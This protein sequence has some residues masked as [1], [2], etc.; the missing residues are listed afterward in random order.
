MRTQ[1]P[2]CRAIVMQSKNHEGPNF[3]PN[4]AN[5]FYLPQDER[6]MPP[7]ILGVLVILVANLQIISQ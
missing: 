1:C 4:C 2:E 7:W 3:C 6:Q 5:L